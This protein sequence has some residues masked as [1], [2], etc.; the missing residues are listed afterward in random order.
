MKIIHEHGQ[1]HFTVEDLPPVIAEIRNGIKSMQV[2]AAYDE[3]DGKSRLSKAIALDNHV[4]PEIVRRVNAF[5][6]LLE[7][8]HQAA[9]ALPTDHGAFET[10]RNAIKKAYHETP[11]V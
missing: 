2:V 3:A 9:A 10:V 1:R 11:P 7:A 6:G 5:D 4:I 8:C